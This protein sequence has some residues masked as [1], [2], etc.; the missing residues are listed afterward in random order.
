MMTDCLKEILKDTRRQLAQCRETLADEKN[1]RKVA[2]NGWVKAQAE[3]AGTTIYWSGAEQMVLMERKME[4]LTKEKEEL[5]D[6]LAD[7]TQRADSWTRIGV[8]RGRK[9]YSN[10][11]EIAELKDEIYK[12][13]TENEKLRGPAV[14]YYMPNIIP[15]ECPRGVKIKVT[16][17]NT[18]W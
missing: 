13:K 17:W 10:N 7:E 12:L 2:E 14:T 5:A 6:K 18:P 9:M 16:S 1:A 3:L 8:K 15:C 11:L 4:K